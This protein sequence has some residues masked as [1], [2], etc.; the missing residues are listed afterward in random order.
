MG[1]VDDAAAVVVA[2]DRV[3]ECRQEPDGRGGV[4]MWARC[5]GQ[6][7]KLAAASVVEG[8]EFFAD[9]FDRGGQS[10]EA[11]PGADVGGGGGPVGG[12]VAP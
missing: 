4:R 3:V 12:E 6:L 5:G 1:V 9:G 7:E 10:G 2:E 11:V 8:D